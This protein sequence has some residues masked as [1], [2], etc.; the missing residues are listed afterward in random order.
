MENCGVRYFVAL[1][2]LF[3]IIRPDLSADPPTRHPADCWEDLPLIRTGVKIRAYSSYNPAGRTFR[4]FMNYAIQAG[5]EYELAQHLGNGMLVQLWFTDIPEERCR[6]L[7]LPLSSF[8]KLRLYLSEDAQPAHERMLDEYF[9]DLSPPSLSPLWGTAFRSRWGFPLLAF[10]ER[11]R[12]ASTQVPHWYQFT[13]HL[14]REP[15]FSEALSAEEIQT[16]SQQLAHPLGTFPGRDQGSRYRS[17]LLELPAGSTRSCFDTIGAGVIRHLRLKLTDVSSEILD[18]I[19][20]RISVDSASDIAAYVPLSVFFGGYLGSPMSNAQGVPCGF[21]G[22]Y[23]YSFFP[24]PFWKMFRVE[25]EN[26]TAGTVSIETNVGWSDTNPY[27]SASTGTFRVKYNDGIEVKAGEPDFPHLQVN[28]SGHIVGTSANLAGSIEGNFR[29]YID[30]SRTPAVE[31]T[32]GEDYFCHAFGIKVGLLTPFHGGLDKKIGYRFHIAD[33]IPFQHSIILA[34]D[35]AHNFSHDR[36]GTF[37]SAVFYYWNPNQFLK[38]TDSIDVGNEGSERA[39]SYE[40]SGS[41]ARL[42]ED[43]ASYEGGFT[44]LIRDAGRWTNGGTKFTAK[45]DPDN[46]GVR[47]RKRINHLAFHQA[48]E[49]HVDGQVA[50]TWFEQG[51]RYHLFPEEPNDW[52]QIDKRFRDTEFEIPASVTRGKSHLELEIKTLTSK[53]ALEPTD[54]GLS[55]EYYYWVFCYVSP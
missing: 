54:E 24:M 9:R 35:H 48:V 14:Y 13:C 19:F 20:I 43:E 22:T 29:M 33:Y 12:A 28:G 47:L 18:N 10:D 8:G 1:S 15:R 5:G 26:R 27:P 44:E 34:Q 32:G 39:H 31:T 45:I 55:N 2:I 25:L 17:E 49:V 53:A 51:S 11:F 38:L 4:D 6:K 7:G 16:W 46:D 36:D 3:A 40:I 30:G 21:D 41:R 50:G 52:N 37:R 42:Q 23:L